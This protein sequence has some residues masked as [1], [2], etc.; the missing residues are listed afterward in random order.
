MIETREL[1]AVY[2]FGTESIDEFSYGVGLLPEDKNFVDRLKREGS[3]PDRPSRNVTGYGTLSLGLPLNTDVLPKRIIW[4][5]PKRPIAD[6]CKIFGLFLV[7]RKFRDI[8]ESLEPN[9]HQFT[10]VNVVWPDGKSA[11][12]DFFW[13]IVAQSLD[14]VDKE[15]TTSPLRYSKI[16][17]SDKQVRLVWR[18][19][20][21]ET[22]AP[23]TF[24]F[25]RDQIGSAHLW[26][27]EY[28]VVGP[29]YSDTLRRA[30]EA[31]GVVGMNH[32]E[33]D[34]VV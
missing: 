28:M 2:Y 7:K 18:S 25:N 26:Q 21:P 33:P 9:V 11:E 20:D 15:Q 27:D 32:P 29:F 19:D 8:V 10:S 17:G 14:G 6:V 4:E 3:D 12:G 13:F 34:K 23:Y 30:C 5:G 1:Q 24:V 16:K 31:A 22:F